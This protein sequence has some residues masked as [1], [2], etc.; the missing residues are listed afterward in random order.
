MLKE[1]VLLKSVSLKI[2][3]QIAVEVSCLDVPLF[4]VVSAFRLASKLLSVV[5]ARIIVPSFLKKIWL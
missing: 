4:S 5:S 2:S 3:H 1:I